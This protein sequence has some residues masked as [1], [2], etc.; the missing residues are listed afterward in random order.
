M[1][2]AVGPQGIK[3]D[4]LDAHPDK[5]KIALWGTG[6]K[7]RKKKKEGLV[8]TPSLNSLNSLSLIKI[9]VRP[10]R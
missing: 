1:K 5:Q 9:E 3:K 4:G 7:N 6:A 10:A 8:P 2:E